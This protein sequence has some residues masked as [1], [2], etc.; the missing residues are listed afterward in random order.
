V[1][2]REREREEIT[3]GWGRLY[4]EELQNLCFSPNIIRP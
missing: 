3:Q 4:N 1:D 2:L